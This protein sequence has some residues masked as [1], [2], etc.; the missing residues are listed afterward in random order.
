M[1]TDDAEKEREQKTPRMLSLDEF[2]LGDQH[3]L[4]QIRQNLP[5]FRDL[6]PLISQPLLAGAPSGSAPDCSN[7]R[8]DA[9]VVSQGLLVCSCNDR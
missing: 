7:V 8:T 3:N 6:M 2:I 9:A 5:E 1:T 4:D